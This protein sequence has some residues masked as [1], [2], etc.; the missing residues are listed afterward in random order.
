M[1]IL[2]DCSDIYN[3]Y[4]RVHPD[5]P[6]FSPVFS[7][8]VVFSSRKS[9]AVQIENDARITV[10]APFHTSQT[11]IQAFLTGHREWVLTHY[12]KQLI[13]LSTSSGSIS[14]SFQDGDLLHFYDRTFTLQVHRV[15]PCNHSSIYLKGDFLVID[16]PTDT[17]EVLRECIAR[18]YR[19]NGKA[20][21]VRRATYWAA[22]MHVT[23]E[24]I[25]LKEQKTR[26]GSCSS[27][28]NLNFNWKLLLMEPRL[29]DYVVVHELA[30]R[31]EMNHSAAFWRIVEAY[32][33]DYRECR[34]ALK[35]S[36]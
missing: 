19:K 36:E 3:A 9:L 16:T 17:P 34:K 7:C 4:C 28:G 25:T 2:L 12:I 32:I 15:P 13:R 31:L 29:L 21:F 26:W 20:V 24:H 30:H 33:P 35:G 1:T 6:A 11:V 22:L 10:R 18:W 14:D 27:L 23:Y 8:E 5:T